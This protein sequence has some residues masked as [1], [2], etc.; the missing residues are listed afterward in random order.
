[1]CLACLL[2]AP[3]GSTLASSEEKTWHTGGTH[4]VFIVFT[5]FSERELKTELN[6]DDQTVRFILEMFPEGYSR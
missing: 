1:M 2:S 5:E 4:K 6:K 3:K